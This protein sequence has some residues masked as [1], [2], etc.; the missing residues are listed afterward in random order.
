[1]PISVLISSSSQA[2]TRAGGGSL[3]T[4]DD[5]AFLDEVG[6][7]ITLDDLVDTRELDVDLECHVLEVAWLGVPDFLCGKG[8][9][10]SCG[11]RVYG[12]IKSGTYG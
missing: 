6:H 1:M 9:T 4:E 5:R 10:D 11:P 8:R 3:G 2:N 12:G 7:E